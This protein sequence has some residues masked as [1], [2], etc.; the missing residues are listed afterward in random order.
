MVAAQREGVAS[1][2]TGQAEDH[3]VRETGWGAGQQ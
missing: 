2:L 3:T 1:N